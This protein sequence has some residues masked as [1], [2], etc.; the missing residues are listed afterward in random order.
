MTDS[1]GWMQNSGQAAA[2]CPNFQVE[3]RTFLT[4]KAVI[5]AVVFTGLYILCLNFYKL[6]SISTP[7]TCGAGEIGSIMKDGLTG[8]YDMKM[9][10]LVT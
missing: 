8:M 7:A 9:L 1:P 2:R 5:F 10:S 4:P 6:Y 3:R